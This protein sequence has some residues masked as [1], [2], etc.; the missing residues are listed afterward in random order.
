MLAQTEGNCYILFL[1][2]YTIHSYTLHESLVRWGSP[3][4]I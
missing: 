1:Y 2:M 4:R 3:V